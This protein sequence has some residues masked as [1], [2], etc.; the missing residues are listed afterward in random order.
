MLNRYGSWLNHDN[1][2]FLSKFTL[3]INDDSSKR[4]KAVFLD[5]KIFEVKYWY[6]CK[7]NDYSSWR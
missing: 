1:V 6:F 3:Q 5:D 2:A 4:N 7:I